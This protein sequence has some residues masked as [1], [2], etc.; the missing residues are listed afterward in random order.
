MASQKNRKKKNAEREKERKKKDPGRRSLKVR[1]ASRARTRATASKCCLT[2]TFQ[3]LKGQI[4]QN[5]LERKQ[6]IFSDH[7]FAIFSATFF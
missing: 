6:M 5:F 4:C 2:R 3:A 7:N 1:V